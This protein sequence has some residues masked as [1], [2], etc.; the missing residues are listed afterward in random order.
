[1]SKMLEA[2]VFCGAVVLSGSLAVGVEVAGRVD[3]RGEATARVVCGVETVGTP[4]GSGTEAWDTRGVADGWAKMSSGGRETNALVMNGC[5]VHGGRLSKD[6]T[7]GTTATNVVRHKVRVGAGRTLV[8]EGGAAVRFAP[9]T[10]ICLE[11]GANLVLRGADWAG[12]EEGTGTGAPWLSGVGVPETTEVA[13]WDSGTAMGRPRLY[14]AGETLGALPVLSRDGAW[15]EGWWTA[16]SG[17]MRVDEETP[18]TQAGG[19]LH[20]RWSAWSLDVK[21]PTETIPADGGTFDAT[22][23]ANVAWSA[24]AGGALWVE[25]EPQAGEGN[26]TV[27]YAVAA[28]PGAMERS[29]TLTVEG[30]GMSRSWSVK[31]KGRE[32]VAK[33]VI[34]PAD[35]TTFNGGARRVA[36]SCATEGAVIRYSTNGKDP[37]ETDTAYSGMSFNVFETTTVKARAYKAGCVPSGVA[38]ARL[39]RLQTLAEAIGVSSWRVTTDG[40]GVWTVDDTEGYGSSSSARSGVISASQLSSLETSVEGSGVLSFRWKTSCEDDPDNDNWDYLAFFADGVERARRD[41]MGDWTEV[42][43][44]LGEGTHSLRWEYRKDEMDDS[45]RTGEDCGWVDAVSWTPLATAESGA[46]PVD[47]LENLGLGSAD[48]EEAA[49]AVASADPDGDGMSTAEEYVAGTDP[50][51]P[52]SVFASQLSMQG[53][54]PT[55]SWEPDL[56]GERR[57]RIWAK[58]EMTDEQWTD[59]TDVSEPGAEGWRFFAVS[60]EDGE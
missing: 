21:A 38:A 36:I 17:G 54:V 48:T 23:T 32:A 3:T 18:A 42:S 44:R 25:I 8:V 24:S 19:A 49:A 55:V 16:V 34:V 39:V 52:E 26:G 41:G 45:G 22:V 27:R 2:V 31:Q 12:L 15:F 20:S 43:V 60:V 51:D 9:W 13:F 4:D 59:V 56:S 33:P 29:A 40:D 35:G 50:T 58:R 53:G 7:W 10:G 6:E 28:N 47:W 37:D 46:V 14:T 1:M 57:Y 11:E 30:G 5:S